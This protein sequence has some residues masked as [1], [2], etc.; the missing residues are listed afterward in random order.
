MKRNGA[1][2]NELRS[3]F[4]LGWV[5]LWFVVGYGPPQA[6]GC[7]AQRRLAHPLIN[8]F[9]YQSVLVLIQFFA[10]HSQLFLFH[11]HAAPLPAA[12]PLMF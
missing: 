3:L 11:S 5:D 1:M 7:T 9:F 10:I 2:K 4:S 12:S 8:H 6:A